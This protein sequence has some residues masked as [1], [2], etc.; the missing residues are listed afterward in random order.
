M[1]PIKVEVY[2]T[3]KTMGV[4]DDKTG[5]KEK[6]LTTV[7]I[8][9]WIEKDISKNPKEGEYFHCINSTYNHPGH[10]ALSVFGDA[11]EF[12]VGKEYYLTLTPVEKTSKK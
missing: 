3:V 9:P 5:R 8:Q 6:L 11:E 12:E 1:N 2:N 10:L 7:N 4:I